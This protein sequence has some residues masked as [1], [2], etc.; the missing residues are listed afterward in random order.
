MMAKAKSEPGPILDIQDARVAEILGAPFNCSVWELARRCKSPASLAEIAALLRVDAASVRLALDELESIG[1]IAR[2]PAG[3]KNR[4]ATYRTTRDELVIE[5]GP[6]DAKDHRIVTAMKKR[7]QEHSNKIMDAARLPLNAQRNDEWT[8]QHFG[9]ARLSPG[10]MKEFQSMIRGVRDFLDGVSTRTKITDVTEIQDCNVQVG[11]EVF[12]I[13]VP[14]APVPRVIFIDRA[15]DGKAVAMIRKSRMSNLSPREREIAD[16]LISGK[17]RPEIAKQL[18]I[19]VN[20][21]ATISKRIYAKLGV[22]RRAE[23]GAKLRGMLR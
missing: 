4:N 18:G 16:E 17:T 1:L 2:L 14:V 15:K 19:S 11:I 3:R 21:I 7:F 13:R 22:R 12:P 8:F 20:T 6:S 5:Y 10:E 9:P 23:L